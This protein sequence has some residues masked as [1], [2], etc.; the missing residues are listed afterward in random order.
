MGS[1]ENRRESSL[2][3]GWVMLPATVVAPV[4]NSNYRFLA[5]YD[6]VPAEEAA[7]EGGGGGDSFFRNSEA[8]GNWGQKRISQV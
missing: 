1:K 2:N 6:R 4:P 7:T 5:S 8:I 3:G